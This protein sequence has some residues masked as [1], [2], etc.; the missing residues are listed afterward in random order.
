[1]GVLDARLERE[2][3]GRGLELAE[4]HQALIDLVDEGDVVRDGG[5]IRLARPTESKAE[6]RALML[7][8][9]HALSED[10]GKPVPLM[11]LLR[12][13]RSR[14]LT[15]ARA[16]RIIGELVDE[17]SIWRDDRGIHLTGEGE[18]DRSKAR[19]AVLDAVRSLAHGHGTGA[20]RVEV[21]DLVVSQGL[22]EEQ[23]RETLEDLLDDGLV[24]DAGGGL[25][26]PG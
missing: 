17:G 13:A 9:V 5:E 6:A 19:K 4:V 25:L 10:R 3:T 24:H 21:I 23:A 20:S 2:L 11:T 22:G 15:T 18:T 26:R 1:T 12:A 14:G 7:E 16:H 8:E